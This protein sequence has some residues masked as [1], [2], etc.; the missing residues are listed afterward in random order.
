MRAVRSIL[1]L[2]VVGLAT[3]CETAKLPFSAG[4]GANPILP[5]PKKSLIPTVII[6]PAKGWPVG[7]QPVSASGTSVTAFAAGLDQAR[8]VA[9]GRRRPQRQLARHCT[10]ELWDTQLIT[11]VDIHSRKAA[12]EWRPG[13]LPG[14]GAGL[15]ALATRAEC[16]GTST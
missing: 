1:M 15:S 14:F 16:L 12:A 10:S 8:C 11:T 13:H 7:T 4:V 2:A 5:P 3:S 6:A 9:G